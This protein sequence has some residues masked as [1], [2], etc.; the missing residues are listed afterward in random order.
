MLLW[1]NN[2]DWRQRHGLPLHDVTELASKLN[3]P[4]DHLNGYS[5]RILAANS[6]G[7]TSSVSNLSSSAKATASMIPAQSTLRNPLRQSLAEEQAIPENGQIEHTHSVQKPA[8]GLLPHNDNQDFANGILEDEAT[9]QLERARSNQLGQSNSVIFKPKAIKQ[10]GKLNVNRSPAK[11]KQG[12]KSPGAAKKIT[13]SHLLPSRT[14]SPNQGLGSPRLI[15]SPGQQKLLQYLETEGF[16]MHSPRHGLSPLRRS[17]LGAQQPEQQSFEIFSD[18][19]NTPPRQLPD[20]PQFTG[21]ILYQPNNN[22]LLEDSL[23][24]FLRLLGS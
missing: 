11:R 23:R 20:N 21:E 9:S 14:S 19:E 18:V 10:R 7:P 2:V 22:I 3:K 17:T 16:P 13:P 24:R 6:D 1:V 15:M 12:T 4:T 5:N 8:I